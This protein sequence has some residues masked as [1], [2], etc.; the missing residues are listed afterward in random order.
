VGSL[1]VVSYNSQGYGGG[2]LNLPLPGGT[3]P[4]IYSLRLTVSRKVTSM[5]Q[6]KA[7]S[8]SSQLK[9]S[10]DINRHHDVKAYG[11]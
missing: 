5:V 6:S 9:L 3:G 7:K 11:E 2:I 1:Y 10:L 8:M 4:C